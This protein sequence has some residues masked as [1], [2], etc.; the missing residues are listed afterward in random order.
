MEVAFEEAVEVL[1]GTHKVCAASHPPTP[2][3]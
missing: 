2:E 1:L 3:G